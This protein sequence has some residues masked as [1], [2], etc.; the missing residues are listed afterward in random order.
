MRTSDY[1]PARSWPGALRQPVPA[2]FSH[3]FIDL[4][5]AEQDRLLACRL[6]QD[7]RML[8][9]ARANLRRWMARD[10]KRVRPVFAEWR[11]LLE[12]LSANHLDY[13]P[14]NPSLSL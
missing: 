11:R 3:A 13:A 8:H 4:R 6:R 7:R 14:G 1:K 2:G 5:N 10:G 12:C 9:L